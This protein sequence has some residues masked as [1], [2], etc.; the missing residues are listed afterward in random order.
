MRAGGVGAAA[1]FGAYGSGFRGGILG[2]DFG[3]WVLGLG[4]RVKG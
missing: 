1:W 2:L 4:F 3:F